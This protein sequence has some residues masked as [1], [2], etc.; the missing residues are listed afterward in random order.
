MS[1]FFLNKPERELLG[2]KSNRQWRVRK[3]REI[4]RVIAAIDDYLLGSA[5]TPFSALDLPE[6]R[7]SLSDL[8]KH[9]KSKLSTY[10]WGK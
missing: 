4:R 8:A 5:H 7:M 2:V 3:R 10:H 9:I 6:E 1:R